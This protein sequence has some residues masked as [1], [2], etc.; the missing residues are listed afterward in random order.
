MPTTQLHYLCLRESSLGGCCGHAYADT[1]VHIYPGSQQWT[2]PELE[3]GFRVGDAA[4]THQVQLHC[5]DWKHLSLLQ[6]ID[7][8][9]P[10]LHW[11][12]LERFL[13]I[14]SSCPTSWM[15]PLDSRIGCKCMAVNSLTRRNPKKANDVAAWN[16]RPAAVICWIVRTWVVRIGSWVWLDVCTSWDGMTPES[17]GFSTLITS[18]WDCHSL[19]SG[20]PLCGAGTMLQPGKR[21]W[22][23]VLYRNKLLICLLQMHRC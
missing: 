7:M 16:I 15:S 21:R 2:M 14:W 9:A 3:Q 12:A 19:D 17:V 5:S 20:D 22:W 11:S 1:G 13:R 4:G 23:V 6:P 18:G 10:F 8:R